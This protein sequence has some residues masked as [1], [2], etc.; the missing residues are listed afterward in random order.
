MEHT[1]FNFGAGKLSEDGPTVRSKW[2]GL[3]SGGGGDLRSCRI[4]LNTLLTCPQLRK[5]P[6][7]SATCDK[8]LLL[9]VDATDRSWLHVVRA[10][11]RTDGR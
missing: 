7:T 2:H 6:F 8:S 11:V 10:V 5:V 4:T 3:P 1:S 9:A